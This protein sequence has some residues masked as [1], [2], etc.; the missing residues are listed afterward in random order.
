MQNSS[1]T[2]Y[3]IEKQF[4]TA[5]VLKK[6]DVIIPSGQNDSLMKTRDNII[7]SVS[8]E[9]DADVHITAQEITELNNFQRQLTQ[10]LNN[11]MKQ[12]SFHGFKDLE[13]FEKDFEKSRQNRD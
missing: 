9:M 3:K 8:S 10:N 6:G 13:Y 1:N 12:S 7:S 2:F 4:T 5:S 11:T